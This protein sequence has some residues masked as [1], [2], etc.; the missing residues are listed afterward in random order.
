[1]MGSCQMIFVRLRRLT[2]NFISIVILLFPSAQFGL[3]ARAQSSAKTQEDFSKRET[4]LTARAIVAENG[5]LLQ[6]RT[7]FEL[8]ILGFEVYRIDD[9]KRALANRT[10]IPGSIFISGPGI[11]LRAGYAYQWFDRNGATDSVYYIESVSGQG[12]RNS[13][14]AIAPVPLRTLP[15][16]EQS[17][18]FPGARSSGTS[19]STAPALLKEYPAGAGEL[20]PQAA[21]GATENQWLAASQTALKISVKKD[22]WY[23]VTQSQMASAGFNPVVDIKNLSLFGDGQEIGI[24]TS[25]DVG[26]LGT[27]D[28][29]EFYGL[30][31]D[32]PTTDTR[33]YYLIAGT[34]SGKRISGEIRTTGSSYAPP[35][36]TYTPPRIDSADRA[37][38]APLI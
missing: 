21:E 24:L 23:R 9:G 20:R 4:N 15:V 7:D 2:T 26:Q 30:G 33:I 34:A 22:G 12:K 19:E 18:V 13:S 1:M 16:S 10:I 25:K 38:F 35:P 5:V 32:T 3:F 28:Y 17:A 37:W 6:W 27:G 8:D 14:A 31:M 29:V 11:P 36:S